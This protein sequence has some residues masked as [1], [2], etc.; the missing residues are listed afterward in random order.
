MCRGLANSN[1]PL[2]FDATTQ[3]GVHTNAIV[4]TTETQTLAYAIYELSGGCA[5]DYA[6]HIL[7]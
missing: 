7:E 3:E 1:A 4:I 5:K 2:A 6:N